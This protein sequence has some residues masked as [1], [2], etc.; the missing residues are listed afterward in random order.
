MTDIRI[1][2]GS[3]LINITGSAKFAG[4]SSNTA[5]FITSSTSNVGVGFDLPQAKLHVSGTTDVFIVEGSGSTIA[6][7]QGSQGQLFSV[8]DSLSGSL[9][10]VNDISGIPILEVFSDDKVVMG[11]FGANTLV[12]SGSKVGIGT[13][14]LTGDIGLYVRKGAGTVI[15][16]ETFSTNGNPD[17]LIVDADNN[18]VRASLQVQGNGGAIESLFV[19]S[20]GLVGIGT[21]TPGSKLSIDDG[22]LEFRTSSPTTIKNKIIFSETTWGDGSFYIEHDG[23]GSGAANILNIFG[24]GSGGAAG[25]IT[26]NRVGNV[27]IGT[28][29]PLKIL[30][31][32]PPSTADDGIR[33]SNSAGGNLISLFQENSTEA[34]IRMYNNN[35]QKI[36]LRAN[37][38]SYFI[39]GNIGIGTSDVEETL[40]I[41]KTNGGDG[42]I[43]G[44]RSDATFSQ[45]EIETKE[46]QVSWGFNASGNRNIYFT[47]NSSE[48]MRITGGGN[49]GIGT[50]TPGAKLDVQG[51]VRVN[52]TAT[53]PALASMIIG[54][55]QNAGS[56]ATLQVGGFIRIGSEIL[57]HQSTANSSAI[58]YDT[59]GLHILGGWEGAAYNNVFIAE[60]GGN[61]GIG[62]T[63]PTTKLDVVGSF[64]ADTFAS[65]QGIDTGNPTPATDELRVSGYGIIGNRGA[66]YF[67]NAVAGGNIQFGIG[68]AHATATKMYIQSDG[69]VGIGTISPLSK[70][71]VNG[72]FRAALTNAN[73]S[74]AVVYNPTSDE[75]TYTF[76]S[77]INGTNIYNSDG[78]LDADRTVDLNTNNI[79]F[80]N[81][82]NFAIST[83]P[84]NET[85][86]LVYYDSG[87]GKLSYGAFPAVAA[88]GSTTQVQYNSGGALGADAGF[89]YSGSRVGIGTTTPLYPLDVTGRARITDDLFLGDIMYH[90]G[91]TNTYFQFG[92]DI[93]YLVAGGVEL[94]RFHETTQD[95]I[96]FNEGGVDVDF[97]VE[98]DN[99]T[100]AF[101]VQGSDGNVGIRT[102]APTGYL[103]TYVSAARYI[104]HI[105]S[106]ADLEILT[107][108]NTNP[109]VT[110]KGTGIADLLNV[111]D[112][113]TEVFTILDGGN[114]GIG[115]TNP[116]FPLAVVGAVSASTNIFA[117]NN[118]YAAGAN[119][120]VFGRSTSEGEYIYRSSE[121]IRIYA[122]GADRLTVA[123]STG[124]VGIGVTTPTYAL[125]IERTSGEVAIQL[126]ARDDTSNSAL[127]FGD[128]SD[129]DVGSLIYNHASNYMSFTT[130]ANERIRINSSGL[131]GI[132]TNNP[133]S[134]LQVNEAG[135]VNVQTIVLGLSST[136]LR[137]VL[138]FSES[139]G[140]GLTTGMSIEYDGRGSGDTNNMYINNVNGD[141]VFTVRS[142]GN[143]GIG[144]TTPGQKLHVIGQ[145]IIDGGAG[146]ASSGTLHV[147]QQGDTSSDGIA[148]TSTN[149]TSHRIW[150]DANGTLNIGPSSLPSSFVQTL[151]GNVGIGTTNPSAKLD[152]AGSTEARYLEVNAI[153][154]F[155]GLS[156]GSAAM[157]EFRNAGDGNTLF[158]KT[159]NSSRT[160][161]APLAVWTENNPR[162][163][164][165]NDGNVGIGT[166]T[167]LSKLHVQGNIRASLSNVNQANF[168]AYNS[169]TGLFTYASTGS[170]VIST[171][172]NADNVYINE[173]ATDADQPV[174]FAENNEE[175]YPVRSNKSIFFYNPSTGTLT[176]P[177][178]IE[179]SALRFKENIVHLTG[180]LQDIEKL[181]GVSYNRIGQTRKEIG[182]I[183]DEVVK[184]LPE[185]VKYQDGEVYGLSYNRVTAVLVEAVKELSDKVNQQE[186]FIQDLADRLKK[187]EDKG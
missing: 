126:Q 99:N 60:A 12:V 181:Q 19:A 14:N 27:G 81:A 8:T 184:I 42:T 36:L 7:I 2:P 59:A 9:M 161:A 137:P 138:Q 146:V 120:F 29:N 182:F 147:R 55:V 46:S 141:P 75:L 176:V 187:L 80:T 164:V 124:N 119:G 23:A 132:G 84:N 52:T 22:N 98:S 177:S 92:S 50:T 26:V 35:V 30:H 100:A 77:S 113:T 129:A 71:H 133:G 149:A 24:D 125:D 156:S 169:S 153:A 183:A 159:Q 5:L 13:A 25:G 94:A 118:I 37:G 173:D 76:T 90:E 180:S 112:N 174:L 78:I 110:I 117:G 105:T 178:L 74:Y 134:R 47:A 116:G 130:N 157:V 127:Y 108:N 63:N 102:A 167:P 51:Q 67:T 61:V 107:D 162:F 4:D 165:R 140:I 170:I 20:T 122:G 40:T 53:I 104:R 62:T 155:A 45:F 16:S 171:A 41:G 83:L 91:D 43:V 79:T 73:Q 32:Q 11:T 97:R 15:K 123:G 58:R 152:I 56:S 95:I 57:L 49:V 3:G 128:N 85:S 143:V 185:L 114:V 172:T 33:L 158:I 65:I 115:I 175:Y 109:A 69:N 166:A 186:I 144:I 54:G 163:L 70:L 64:K 168:V 68:G 18:N 48:V 145:A 82:Q 89:V 131:V 111:F 135:T 106:N 103:E 151:T 150:K 28:T 87:N 17:V 39:G 101:F 93:I 88:A 121:D 21:V 31:V 66:L 136:S 10:S 148:L 154:G 6:D 34:F 96:V 72:D 142:G 38:T 179:S 139:T 86:E 160:D 44:L 1:I